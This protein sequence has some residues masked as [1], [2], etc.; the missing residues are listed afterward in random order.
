[1]LWRHFWFTLTPM[2][3]HHPQL[4][5][6]FLVFCP[7]RAWMSSCYRKGHLQGKV[8]NWGISKERVFSVLKSDIGAVAK[9]KLH[10][11]QQLLVISIGDSQQPPLLHHQLP[12][13]TTVS[14]APP[15]YQYI[16]QN[17]IFSLFEA[18]LKKIL[19]RQISDEPVA[20]ELFCIWR[21][22]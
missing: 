12:I 11:L 6:K 7:I 1:M 2:Q 20:S 8:Q 15:R 10:L 21:R 16:G 3:Y 5:I 9:G 17:R 19:P 4:S 22:S 14:S 18:T 13:H